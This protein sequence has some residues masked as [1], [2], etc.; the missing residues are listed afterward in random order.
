[1]DQSQ[2][3][4][5]RHAPSIRVCLAGHAARYIPHLICVLPWLAAYLPRMPLERRHRID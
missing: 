5:T 1:M 2:A 3:R 4:T